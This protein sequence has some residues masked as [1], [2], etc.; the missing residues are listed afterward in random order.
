MLE[1]SVR[2]L[3][4]FMVLV[5]ISSASPAPAQVSSHLFN[6]SATGGV[7]SREPWPVVS[8]GGIRVMENGS[9]WGEVN[10]APGVYEWSALDKWLAKAKSGGQDVLYTFV[11]VPKWASSRP[12]DTTCRMGP[13]TCDAP[14][15][16]NADGTGTDQYWK[17]FVTALTAHNKAGSGAHIRYWELW[18]EPHN[19][20]SWNGTNAQLVRMVK[21]AYTIIKASDS[22]AFILSPTL[23]WI[24]NE[25]LTWASTYLAAGGSKYVDGIA[26]HGYVMQQLKTGAKTDNPETLT[27]LLP[28]YKAMLATFGLSSK[29][30][31]NTESSWSLN[32]QWGP[33]S[34]DP[35]MQTAFVSRL[36]ILHAAYGISRLYWFEWNDTSDG[37]LWL[38]DP[39][40][41]SAPGTVLKPGIAY[42]ATY[43]WLV[44]NNIS[45]GC[46]QT[47]T[48][49]KCKIT[50][51]SGYVA[52]AVWD[53]AE[54]C[55]S[56][57][58]HTVSYMPDAKYIHY[59][60]L[61]G[62][63]HSVTGTTVP[64]GAKPILLQ[65]R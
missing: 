64:I 25:A 3:V 47:A 57:S 19:K 12:G 4:G 29:P 45:K 34:S 22:N 56:G 55:S 33:F 42:Q 63:T 6:L 17:D 53:T 35:D 65:N 13:G 30:I 5:L 58:C 23:G 54:S 59:Q 37:T 2:V 26:L 48:I 39:R 24:T 32:G 15:D 52:E 16:L 31:F 49:W 8:F 40:D 7:T 44:G 9:S 41:A 50:G 61:D 11:W 1:K 27:T 10:T 60:T 51:A 21:D 36:Y 62:K 18:N 43:T 28:P 38:K 46:T 14:S 20:F